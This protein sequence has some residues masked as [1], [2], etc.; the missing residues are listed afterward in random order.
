MAVKIA[1]SS[2][3]ENGRATG[4]VAGDQNGREVRIQDWYN[5]GWGYVIRFK[6]KKMADKFAK[7]ME[8]A[9]NNNKIG[10]DQNGRN[11]VLTEAEKVGW[12]LSKITTPCESDCSSLATVCTISAGVPKSAVFNGNCCTTRTLRSKLQATGLVDVFSDAAHTG[13]DK[14]ALRGD[15]YLKEGNHVVVCITDG[16]YKNQSCRSH[17]TGN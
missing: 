5:N 3:D 17:E 9:A 12:D 14:N 6:D 7:A 13:S 2:I 15:I 10:Y 8:D 11:T 4:G 1:H 16:N